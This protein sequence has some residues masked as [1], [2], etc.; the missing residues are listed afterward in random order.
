VR[1]GRKKTGS[2][3]EIALKAISGRWK[4]L[5]LHELY[6]RGNRFAELRRALP[7]ISEK[8]LS[9]ELKQLENDG[10][11]VRTLLAERP[12]KVEYSVTRLGERLK[13]T[14]SA[15]QQWGLMYLKTKPVEAQSK[16]AVPVDKSERLVNVAS[17]NV[18]STGKS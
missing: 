14:I 8:I 11:I 4:L 3:A 15:M 2:A 7:G 13:P 12:I 10:I 18:R 1:T 16:T 17:N 9:E 5:I 6:F